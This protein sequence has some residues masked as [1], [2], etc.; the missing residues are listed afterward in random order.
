M[1]P[2]SVH[3]T[4]EEAEKVSPSATKSTGA[5]YCRADCPLS[6]CTVVSWLFMRVCT[7]A[8]TIHGTHV[9]VGMVRWKQPCGACAV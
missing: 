2:F 9:A 7:Y 6:I 5:E 8:V 3:E 4:A 1:P